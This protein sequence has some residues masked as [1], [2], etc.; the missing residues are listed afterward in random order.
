M[1]AGTW[2]NVNFIR[3]RQ[4]NRW[5]FLFRLCILS[6]DVGPDSFLLFL[7]SIG[8]F[9]SF[10]SVC[11]TPLIIRITLKFTNGTQEGRKRD[12][13]RITEQELKEERAEVIYTL[14]KIILPTNK[15][16]NSIH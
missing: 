15:V 14:R 4:R 6:A 3:E 5:G 12:F 10:M 7:P 16:W 9:F 1:R 11:H 13:L 8:F 2:G